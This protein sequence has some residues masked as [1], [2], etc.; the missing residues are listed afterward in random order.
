MLPKKGNRNTKSLACTSLVPPILEY[1]AVCW[2]PCRGH[3]NALD[4]VQKKAAQFTD[5]TKDSDC[6]TLDQ[7][8]TIASL[9]A[10]FEAYCGEPAWKAIRDRLRRPYY[11]SRVDHVRKL[12]DRK[13]RTDIGKCSFV[14]RTIKN[15]NQLPAEGLVKI[16]RKRVREAIIRG[17]KRKE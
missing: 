13:Q 1:G 14:S 17:M 9:Y 15:W 11:F 8:R 3:I 12:R 5:P 6:E 4:R 10:P 7:L 2:D 16:F